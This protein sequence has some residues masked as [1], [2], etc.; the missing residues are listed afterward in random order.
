LI[1]DFSY[2]LE[3]RGFLW[4]IA[5]RVLLAQVFSREGVAKM[6]SLISIL[7]GAKKHGKQT[8][9]E[10][11]QNRKLR[12]ES[13]EPRQ[14]LAGGTVLDPP[15]ST[16]PSPNHV[17][18]TSL[19]VPKL[20]ILPGGLNKVLAEFN[21]RTTSGQVSRLMGMDFVGV[22]G[23]L[24]W[25][26]NGFRLM[27]DMNGRASDGCETPI[28]YGRADYAT[29][30]VR[31]DVTG[32]PFWAGTTARKVQLVGDFNSR[33][34]SDSVA[35]QLAY[36]DFSDARGRLVPEESVKYSGVAPVVHRLSSAG[37]WVS[38][39]WQPEFSTAYTGE[40]NV[41]LFSFDMGANQSDRPVSE[42]TLEFVKVQGSM[43]NCQSYSIWITRWQPELNAYATTCLQAGV[44]PVNE[45]LLFKLGKFVL[46]GG[47]QFTVR[48]D[49]ASNLASDTT[50]SLTFGKG[51]KAKDL[52]TGKALKGVA[53][54][55]GEGQIQI[56][57]SQSPVIN[58]VKVTSP[59]LYVSE[60][61]TGYGWEVSPYA[62]NL[63]FESL[64]VYANGVDANITQI[65]IG[66]AQGDLSDCTNYKLWG[67]QNGVDIILATGQAV[68]EK[69]VFNF[70]YLVFAGTSAYFEV[71]ADVAAS[72]VGTSLRTRLTGVVS[73]T[74][75]VD[76]I[77]ARDQAP[78]SWQFPSSSTDVE[79]LLAQQ[80][81][82]LQAQLLVLQGVG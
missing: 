14:M 56:W 33:L 40:K 52:N 82:Q 11:R 25:D 61:S 51:W 62:S 8:S 64:K 36:A 71:H 13:L 34:N 46:D 75:I 6:T 68:G 39:R 77:F 5:R 43:K 31:L 59:R 42:Q 54:G 41:S 81:A 57:K 20:D 65:V 70:Q 60:T 79:D 69:M 29:E 76:G 7:F 3:L 24:A 28:A 10:R 72:P 73:S 12:V 17:Q 80:I 48:A 30:T 32:Q 4:R 22:A 19:K 45:K 26:T 55:G 1:Y 58:F 50:L 78:W 2:S 74:A 15:V 27:A 47:Y 49:V 66:A 21:M 9:K 53:I 37:F 23:H 18:V 38:Q 67:K 16:V 63:M 44:K 35:V